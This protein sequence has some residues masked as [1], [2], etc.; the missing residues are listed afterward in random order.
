MTVI[1]II[2]AILQLRRQKQDLE[3]E[4]N[5]NPDLDASQK[6]IIT[7]KITTICI[8]NMTSTWIWIII[9]TLMEL[10]IW[11]IYTYSILPDTLQ[12]N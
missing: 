8:A 11:W 3:D 7:N 4:I 10:L 5:S 9:L 12:S 1:A 6:E 2:L